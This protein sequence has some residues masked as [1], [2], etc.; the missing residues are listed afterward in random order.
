MEEG[1][2]DVYEIYYILILKTRYEVHLELLPYRSCTKIK[3]RKYNL[4]Y[5]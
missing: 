2:E 4:H 3:H 1:K 5:T